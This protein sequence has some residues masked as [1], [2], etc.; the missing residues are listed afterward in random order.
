MFVTEGLLNEVRKI[1]HDDAAVLR[2]DTR[3]QP[4]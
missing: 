3:S 1:R 4:S 2:V